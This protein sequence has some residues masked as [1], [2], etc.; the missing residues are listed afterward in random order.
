MR[1][2]RPGMD[3]EF[4]GKGDKWKHSRHQILTVCIMHVK[5]HKD[6]KEDVLKEKGMK[7]GINF[8]MNKKFLVEDGE[9]RSGSPGRCT[10]IPFHS[11]F[12]Y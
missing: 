1:G 6:D 4:G 11:S 9:L 12:V 2:I 7:R 8:E 3:R 10:R 5:V